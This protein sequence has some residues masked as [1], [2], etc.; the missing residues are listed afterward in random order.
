MRNRLTIFITLI[1]GFISALLAQDA[2]VKPGT[3]KSTIVTPYNPNYLEVICFEDNMDL[4]DSAS[5]AS[6]GWI[7]LNV[8]GGGSTSWFQGNPAVFPAFEGTGYAAQNYQGANGFYLDQWTIS[9]LI[10]VSGGDTICFY[11]RAPDA[12]PFD[13]SIYVRLSTTGGTTPGDF[14]VNYGRFLVSE[15]GWDLWTGVIAQAGNIR[16]AIQYQ[17][18]DGG[19]AGNNSNY[20]G[21]DL[22]Q[23]KGGCI[24]PVELTSFSAKP[25]NGTINLSW[26]TATE[27][28]N[29]GFEVQ[30]KSTGDFETIAFVEGNGTTTETQNYSFVDSRVEASSYIYR[31]KQIDYDGTFAYS[32]EVEVDV[33]VPSEFSLSQNY[34][35]PFN[36]STKISFS[37]PVESY[38]TLKI[39]NI[40][41]EEVTNLINRT[42]N[43]GYHDINFDAS[44]LNS[45][46]YFYQIE[47]QGIDGSSFSEVRKMM[48]TK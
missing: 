3:E 1:F 9:P 42:V 27:T 10:E 45:G 44:N 4:G 24:L 16:F 14:D 41:G 47:A 31:L 34:P 8:D 2:V 36:P 32:K 12:N 18:F 40:I 39:F 19:P 28:N 15:S 13:D 43:A 29:Q 7:L 20:I 30:R 48:L 11:H 5:L 46:I 6:R 35:N 25:V 21:I 26:T 37:L 33:V 23:V 38:V 17:I 22:V